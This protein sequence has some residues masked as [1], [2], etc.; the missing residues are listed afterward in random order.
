[1]ADLRQRGQEWKGGWD[2]NEGEKHCFKINIITLL[3][4]ITFILS[5]CN[6]ATRLVVF[7]CLIWKKKYQKV[8]NGSS[9]LLSKTGPSHH[10]CRCTLKI[11]KNREYVQKHK[12]MALFCQRTVGHSLTNSGKPWVYLPRYITQDGREGATVGLRDVALC[13]YRRVRFVWTEEGL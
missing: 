2:R 7:L 10:G 3:E 9:Y 4:V 11:K 13:C 1:M 8:R 6:P 12:L 5:A